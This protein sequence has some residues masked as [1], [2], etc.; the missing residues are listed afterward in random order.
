MSGF[1]A[2]TCI[3]QRNHTYSVASAPVVTSSVFGTAYRIYFQKEVSIIFFVCI[4]IEILVIDLQDCLWNLMSST[5]AAW[6]R[7]IF[8]RIWKHTLY[9]VILFQISNILIHYQTF[10]VFCLKKNWDL[11]CTPTGYL[12]Q[13]VSNI[14]QY[15]FE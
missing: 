13:I 6:F 9:G 8:L 12:K 10:Q 2:L 14:K 7:A 4:K 15:L 11:K 1:C 5:G 3:W